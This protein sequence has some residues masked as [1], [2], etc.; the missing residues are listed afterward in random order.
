MLSSRQA[1]E[2]GFCGTQRRKEA[3]RI[4]NESLRRRGILQSSFTFLCAAQNETCRP[5][6]DVRTHST[7]THI[8]LFALLA[9][10]PG[11]REYF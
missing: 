3:G 7:H 4:D 5:S 10:L 6:I 9:S 8:C 11:V 1:G 2:I